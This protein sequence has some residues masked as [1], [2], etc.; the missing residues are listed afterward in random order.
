MIVRDS[1]AKWLYNRMFNWLVHR[2]SASMV[3]TM[4]T[5]QLGY[6]GVLDIFGFEIFEHNTFEQLCINF[7][8]EKLQ[9]TCWPLMC[10][11]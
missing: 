2:I 7:C 1:L 8:N 4:S 10:V 6:I 3:P 9:N 5:S 11:T